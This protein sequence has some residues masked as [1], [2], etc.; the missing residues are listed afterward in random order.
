MEQAYP[1]FVCWGPVPIAGGFGGMR[2]ITDISGCAPA[3]GGGAFVSS[4]TGCCWPHPL[5]NASITAI[6][7]RMGSARRGRVDRVQSK[8]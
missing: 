1:Y 2:F 7:A 4:G 5:T 8:E 3:L 6:A